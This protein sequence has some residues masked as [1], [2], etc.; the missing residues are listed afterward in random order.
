MN[1]YDNSGKRI[2][3]DKRG[4]KVEELFKKLIEEEGYRCIEATEDQNKYQHWDWCTVKDSV[5]DR[6]D[7]KGIKNNA[8]PGCTWFELQ[9]NYG[10]IGWGRSEFMNTIAF[11]RDDCFEFVNRAELLTFVEGKIKEEDER[12][13][14][15]IVYVIKDGLLDY[16]RYWRLLWGRDDRTVTVPFE[17]FKHLVFKRLKK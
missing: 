9:N 2:D 13:G 16:Q 7:V 11:E 14:E 8:G 1:E 4:R 3:D 15:E 12:M 6:V 5:Y 10:G 17:D